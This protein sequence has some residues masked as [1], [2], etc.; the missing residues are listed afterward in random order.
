MRL[1]TNT[2]VRQFFVRLT[3]GIHRL[4]LRVGETNM[5]KSQRKSDGDQV[6]SASALALAPA[7]RQRHVMDSGEFGPVPTPANLEPAVVSELVA[8]VNRLYRVGGLQ[9]A[10]AIGRYLIAACFEGDAGRVRDPRRHPNS[11]R[12]LAAREDL[13]V[14]ASYL[15]NAVAVTE[16]FALLPSDLA[17]SLP[18]AHH[19][20]LL[21]VHDANSKV[22][23]AHQAL[24][25]AWSSRELGRAIDDKMQTSVVSKAGRPKIP[26]FVR[27]IR[28]LE[29]AATLLRDSE[30]LD[31][32]V[33]RYL[34]SA[35]VPVLDRA[36]AALLA[37]TPAI[38]RMN[39][40][41]YPPDESE[42][43]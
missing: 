16:Q 33:R 25:N 12:E 6:Q 27:G 43:E 36:N 31:I 41:V 4:T 7:D 19:R 40:L 11:F 32:E 29:E 39:R 21:V 18:F 5:S 28:L 35:T 10:L 24:S 20:K 17:E 1:C 3:N 30:E 2:H 15:F 42:A 34:L 23:L 13:M 37:L 14:K 9:T 8:E 38:E 26:N 22:D